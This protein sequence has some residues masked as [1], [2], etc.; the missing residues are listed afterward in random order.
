VGETRFHRDFL[1]PRIQPEHA[2]AAGLWTKQVEQAFDRGGFAGA[3]A[4]EETVTA[5]GAHGEIET[6]HGL[7]LSVAPGQLPDFDHWCV[8]CVHSDLLGVVLDEIS[9]SAAAALRS[10]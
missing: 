7:D 9:S 10:K 6:M 2:D 8:Q 3:V 1:F 5:P 4:A